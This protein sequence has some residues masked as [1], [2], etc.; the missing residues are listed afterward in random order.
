MPF[1]HQNQCYRTFDGVQWPNFCDVLDDEEKRAIAEAKADGARFKMRK[2]PGG[3]A[4]AF[5]HP[6]DLAAW[7][8]KHQPASKE[9]Q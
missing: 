5:I 6:D 7:L 2:H 4:Q 8:A 9:G 1:K 3:F